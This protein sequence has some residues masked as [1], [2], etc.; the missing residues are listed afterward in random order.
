M[1]T[2]FS[3]N[4]RPIVLVL[5]VFLTGLNAAY[6]TVDPL[7]I[8]PLKSDNYLKVESTTAKLLRDA[9]IRK[10]LLNTS[11]KVY[12][13]QQGKKTS[14][15]S[16]TTKVEVRVEKTDGKAK[17]EVKICLWTPGIHLGTTT[18][19]K[20]YVFESGNYKRTKTFKVFK[21]KDKKVIVYINNK[22]VTNTFSYKLR[23]DEI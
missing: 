23:V 4:I 13:I 17:T 18:V 15:F 9:S 3:K 16:N 21:A 5:A 19:K 7:S 22:S 6:G 10:C 12:S 1:I 20:T 2:F 11:G 14:A 8:S